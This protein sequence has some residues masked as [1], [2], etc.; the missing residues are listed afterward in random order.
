MLDRN[1]IYEALHTSGIRLKE[2]ILII[3]SSF[4]L[5]PQMLT[6]ILTPARCHWK[7]KDK[8]FKFTCESNYVTGVHIAYVTFQ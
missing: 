5:L 2:T 6:K 3:S 7:E 8:F 1:N 4:E